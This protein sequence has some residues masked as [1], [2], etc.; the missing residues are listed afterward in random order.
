MR[1]SVKLEF[2]NISGCLFH[3]F[4]IM[5]IPPPPTHTPGNIFLPKKDVA[6]QHEFHTFYEIAKWA[7]IWLFLDFENLILLTSDHSSGK[8]NLITLPV[9]TFTV[10]FYL[11][12]K[13]HKINIFG[14]IDWMNE[15]AVF[16]FSATGKKKK[17]IEWM[18]NMWTFP[19]KKNRKNTQNCGKKNTTYFLIK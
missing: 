14:E 3:T 10:F 5:P 11:P 17:E 19:G 4:D 16:F 13:V 1:F 6:S 8:N 15:K 12:G 18:N 7:K 9:V 2:L